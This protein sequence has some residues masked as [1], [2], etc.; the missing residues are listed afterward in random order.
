MQHRR[1][2]LRRLDPS[3]DDSRTPPAPG[4]R[5]LTQALRRRAVPDG[6]PEAAPHVEDPTSYLIAHEDLG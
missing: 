3:D 1:D 5:T 6:E 2:G 4:R